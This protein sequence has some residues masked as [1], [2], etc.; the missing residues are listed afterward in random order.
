[1]HMHTKRCRI[2]RGPCSIF[3]LPPFARQQQLKFV[4]NA[5]QNTNSDKATQ[6]PIRWP[7][8]P[9]A[10]EVVDDEEAVGSSQFT[11]PSVSGMDA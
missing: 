8:I 2:L 6:P 10:V 1:M 3:G 9:A 4:F 11:L 7:Q 5:S